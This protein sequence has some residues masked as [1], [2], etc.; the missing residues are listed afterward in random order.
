VI[1][2]TVY[3]QLSIDT[4]AVNA[5]L[6]SSQ[7]LAALSRNGS[8]VTALFASGGGTFAALN[9]SNLSATGATLVLGN[10]TFGGIV[11]PSAAAA[12]AAARAAS[13][14]IAAA[15]LL[16]DTSKS[17]VIAVCTLTGF[18]LGGATVYTVQASA[19]RRRTLLLLNS[20]TPKAA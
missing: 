13:A 8:A 17:V 14:G 1:G 10:N 4:G 5:T 16:S 15:G 19:E 3:F 6:L 2:T 18:M 20:V 9:I 11:P 12:S 7:A